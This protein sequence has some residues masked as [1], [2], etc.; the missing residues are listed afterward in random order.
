MVALVGKINK[1][2]TDLEN[3][4]RYLGKKKGENLKAV[5]LAQTREFSFSSLHA[6]CMRHLICMQNTWQGILIE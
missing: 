1:H 5:K 4:Q 2:I 3:V 6:F